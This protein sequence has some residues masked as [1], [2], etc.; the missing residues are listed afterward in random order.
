MC[1]MLH[2]I[3]LPVKWHPNLSNGLCRVHIGPPIPVYQYTEYRDTGLNGTGIDT[4][5]A[6]FNT[7]V[8]GISNSRSHQCDALHNL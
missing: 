3:S 6:L 2:P 8:F 7:V 4:G 1:Q 5:I